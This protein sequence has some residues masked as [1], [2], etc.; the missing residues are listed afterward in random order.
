MNFISF[1]SQG[2]KKSSLIK[3][4]DKKATFLWEKKTFVIRDDELN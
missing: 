2:K 3:F 1:T 4:Y